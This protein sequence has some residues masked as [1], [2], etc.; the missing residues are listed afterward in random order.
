[1]TGRLSTC[2]I[3]PNLKPLLPPTLNFS[4]N[5]STFADYKPSYLYGGFGFPDP[6]AFNDVYILSL[7]SFKWIKAYNLDPSAPSPDPAGHGGCSANVVNHDQMIIIGGWFGQQGAPQCDSPDTQG[8]HNMILGNNTA[9]GAI[10]DQYDPKLSKY[11]V[12]AAIIS[13]IGGG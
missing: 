5:R 2:E 4:M 9:K 6:L 13:A 1:M 8:L 3:T 10:W 7:P 11:E 12:P